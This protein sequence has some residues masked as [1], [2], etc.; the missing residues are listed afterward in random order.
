M[1][2]RQFETVA[3][4][5]RRAKKRL[6]KL[7]LTAGDDFGARGLPRGR[8]NQGLLSHVRN[9]NI[10]A[11]AVL[12]WATR[13]G[14]EMARRGKVTGTI[15]KGKLADLA[16]IRGNPT[17]DISV[18]GEDANIVAVIKDGVVAAGSLS[19]GTLQ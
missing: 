12:T 6:P 8:Q 14:A 17:Q 7:K 9:T 11:H 19:A 5:Q 2:T 4:A 13:N 15:E 16:I 3:E 18:M 1:G 10:P